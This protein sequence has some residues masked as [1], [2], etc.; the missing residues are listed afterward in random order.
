M[1][2]IELMATKNLIKYLHE[3]NASSLHKTVYYKSALLITDDPED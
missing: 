1:L 2:V 3:F